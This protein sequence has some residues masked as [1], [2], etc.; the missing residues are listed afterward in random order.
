MAAKPVF[1]PWLT[2]SIA[3]ACLST[4]RSPCDEVQLAVE[5]ELLR[6]S[7]RLTPVTHGWVGDVLTLGGNFNEIIQGKNPR[8]DIVIVSGNI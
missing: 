6:A 8:P 7:V 3:T 5:P 2:W 4:F 1:F